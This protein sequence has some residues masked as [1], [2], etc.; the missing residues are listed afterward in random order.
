[1]RKSALVGICLVLSGCSGFGKF[2]TDTATLPGANPNAPGGENL[3]MRRVRGYSTAETPL[4]PAGGNIWPGPPAPLPTLEDVEKDRI[5]TIL[6]GAS[7]GGGSQLPDGGEMSVGEPD[8]QPDTSQSVT[9]K[10]P[11]AEPDAASKYGVQRGSAS[12]IEIPN[13]DGTVTLIHPD[14]SVTTTQAKKTQ[15]PATPRP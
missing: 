10:L 4:L 13:G 1:M 6:G 11:D 15:A 12:T 8:G 2:V 3:N 7:N 9:G 5:G 14:G